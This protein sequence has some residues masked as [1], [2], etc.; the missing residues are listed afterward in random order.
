MNLASVGEIFGLDGLESHIQ[1]VDEGLLRR[2]NTDNTWLQD[3][4]VRVVNGGGKRLRPILVIASAASGGGPIDTDVLN[5]AVAVELVHAGSLVHDDIIDDARERRGVITVNA[6]EGVDHAIL[7]GDYLLARA[8]EAA[9][10][11]SKEVAQE[12]ARTLAD[13]CDGQSREQVDAYNP[14]RTVESALLTIRGKTAALMRASCTIGGLCARLPD[15]HVRALS[16]FG[17]SFGMSFQ[18]IDDVLNVTSTSELLGKPAGIDVREGT[19]TLPVLFALQDGGNSSLR[20]LL[21]RS[22]E[23]RD[24]EQILEIVRSGDAL[25]RTIELVHEYNDRA[26]SSLQGL[27][28]NSVLDGFRQLPSEYTEWALGTHVTPSSA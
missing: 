14:D 22:A 7:V 17:E 9:A 4:A 27:S 2:L 26:V 23:S 8:G 3:P 1:A 19:Y 11:V 18:I 15:D 6:Y 21:K 10:A 13:L 20:G 12:L 28:P 16:S 24:T 5:G 25:E